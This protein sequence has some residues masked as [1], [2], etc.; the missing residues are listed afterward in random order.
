[1]LKLQKR[2]TQIELHQQGEFKPPPFY[3]FYESK[4]TLE[5]W[6][7]EQNPTYEFSY[8]SLGVFYPNN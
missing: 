6:H 5:Q 3:L 7:K 8:C 1:M 4:E 2:L